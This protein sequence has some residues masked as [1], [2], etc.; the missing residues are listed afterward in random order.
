MSE[1]KDELLKQ[2]SNP[3]FAKRAE[4]SRQLGSYVAD[5]SV[6]DALY[7]ALDDHEVTVRLAVTETLNKSLGS[8]STPS[9]IRREIINVLAEQFNDPHDSVRH[10]V[11][12]ALIHQLNHPD[13]AV[14]AASADALGDGVASPSVREALMTRLQ[15]HSVGVRE[16][17]VAA[18][19]AAADDPDVAAA[20][21]RALSDPFENVRERAAAAL[22]RD[23]AAGGQGFAGPRPGPALGF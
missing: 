12:Q 6:R 21:E 14:R 10:T 18:L 13:A 5:R 22:R 11:A 7:R 17:A 1:I 4:A 3:D 23:H 8:D 19:S 15:D 9:D 20:L 16:A 2:L